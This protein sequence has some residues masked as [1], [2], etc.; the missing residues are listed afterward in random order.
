MKLFASWSGG[1]DCMLALYRVLNTRQHTVTH[2]VN[3]VNFDGYSKSHGLKSS[4]IAQQASALDMEI[5]QHPTDDKGYEA[6]FKLVIERL[7]QEGVTGGVFGDIYL[8]V[9]RDWIER[10]C[11]EMHIQ[12]FFPLWNSSTSDLIHEFV[13]AGFKAMVVSVNK[14]HLSKDWLGR[15]LDSGFVSDILRMENID[16]CAENGEYHSFVYDGPIFKN[17]VA[18]EKGNDYFKDDHWFIELN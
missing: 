14:K 13:D 5:V 12:P 8:Q 1:K 11:S 3:M 18:L 15:T 6:N 9:H 7:K 17:P 2:L 4:L 10:V 16:P